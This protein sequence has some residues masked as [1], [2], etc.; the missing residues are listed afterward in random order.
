M[1]EQ[2][3]QRELTALEAGLAALA[4]CSPGID[5]DYLF[6]HAGRTAA[7]GGRGVWPYTTALMAVLALGLGWIAVHRPQPLPSIDQPEPRF[8]YIHV[9]K[10]PTP[11][12]TANPAHRRPTPR[13]PDLGEADSAQELASGIHVR[14]QVLLMGVDALPSA[15]APSSPERR[16]PLDPLLGLPATIL[17]EPGRNILKGLQEL[18]S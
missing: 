6:Y 2:S 1:S 10:S 15:Q 4:P 8:V 12:S 9:D 18:G 5:R 7:R 3:P 16:P 13:I 14:E 11:T 17:D